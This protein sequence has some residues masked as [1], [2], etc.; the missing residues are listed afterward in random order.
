MPVK[1]Y[2]LSFDI[3]IFFPFKFHFRRLDNVNRT[4]APT[5]TSSPAN[6]RQSAQ[7]TTTSSNREQTSTSRATTVEGTRSSEVASATRRLRFTNSASP[8][9]GRQVESHRGQ[10]QARTSREQ[11]N[12]QGLTS[13]CMQQAASSKELEFVIIKLYIPSDDSGLEK[14]GKSGSSLQGNCWDFD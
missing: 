6:Q 12:S 13:H 1:V 9:R 10:Q 8:S 3:Y 11:Q 5:G 14:L 2:N 4:G 7:A